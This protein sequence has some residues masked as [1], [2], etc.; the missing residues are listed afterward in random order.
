VTVRRT[1]LALILALGLA[2]AAHAEPWAAGATLPALELP[3]QHGEA[4]AI[5][6]S[7]RVVVF[8]RD[9]SAG[10]IVK[11]AVA[12]AGNDLFDRNRA[13]YV[14]DL[15]GMPGFVRSMFAMPGLRRRPYKLMV[16][17]E[18]KAT[19]DFPSEEG[20]PT[21]LVLKDLRIE[22]VSYPADADALIALLQP[23]PAQP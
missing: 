11:E 18:G 3:D 4:R 10:R 12:K 2:A 17:E 21:V 6:P 14:V 9:M 1:A 5:E 13:V 20:K 16:D 15:A 8:S 22:S 7:T 19:A 23:A